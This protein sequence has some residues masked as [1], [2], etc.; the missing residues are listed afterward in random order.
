MTS[1]T[2]RSTYEEVTEAFVN[3]ALEVYAQAR[4]GARGAEQLRQIERLVLLNVIDN[5]WREHLYEMDYLQEGIGLRAM[6][7][8]DPLVEYQR[9]GYDMFL[10]MQETIKEDFARYVFHV[11]AVRDDR[12]SSTHADAPGTPADPDGA[13][14]GAAGVCRGREPKVILLPRARG[15]SVSRKPYRTRSRATR[16]APA[17]VAR[18]TSSVTAAPELPPSSTTTGSG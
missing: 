15:L 6:A 5:R 11:E 12:A 1:T 14:A 7:Q 2:R 10:Q 8:R 13:D 18:S 9:E 16:R 17:A 4:G 3:D